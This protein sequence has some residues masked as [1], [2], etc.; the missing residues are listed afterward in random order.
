MNRYGWEKINLTQRY[1]TSHSTPFFPALKMKQKDD[2]PHPCTILIMIV[3][4]LGIGCF[5]VWVKWALN[6]E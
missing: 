3:F 2:D 1:R 6:M 5:F 4:G